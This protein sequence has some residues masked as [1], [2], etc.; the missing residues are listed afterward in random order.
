MFKLLFGGDDIMSILK[1]K[2]KLLPN[3]VKDGKMMQRIS[4]DY[5]LRDVDILSVTTVSN[6]Y[7]ADVQLPSDVLK[8]SP[9]NIRVVVDNYPN[10]Q[11]V[12][13]TQGRIGMPIPDGTTLTQAKLLLTGVLLFY[14][15]ALP[16]NNLSNYL[17]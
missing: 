10:I 8:E 5:M 15:L 9:I 1:R 3:G 16:K 14:Q 17:Y 12:F 2:E 6:I 13:S 4:N 7:V 11:N